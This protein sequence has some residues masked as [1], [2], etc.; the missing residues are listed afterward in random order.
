MLIQASYI[1]DLQMKLKLEG[2]MVRKVEFPEDVFESEPCIEVEYNK[3]IWEICIADDGQLS[4]LD[5]DLLIFQID[6]SYEEVIQ[7]IKTKKGA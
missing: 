4:L 3:K 2:I 5:C 6:I 1:K 7:E